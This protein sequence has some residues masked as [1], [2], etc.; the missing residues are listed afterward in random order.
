MDR[1]L[2]TLEENENNPIEQAE[3]FIAKIPAQAIEANDTPKYIPSKDP[4]LNAGHYAVY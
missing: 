3:A 1:F 2:P 4:C